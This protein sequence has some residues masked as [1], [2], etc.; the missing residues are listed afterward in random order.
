MNE[1][2]IR[3]ATEKDFQD[4]NNLMLQVH[5][6]HTKA[7]PDIYRENRTIFSKERFS[8]LVDEGSVVLATSGG[9]TVGAAVCLI[10]HASSPNHVGRTVMFLDSIV[11]D[12]EFRN[13]GVGRR[14]VESIEEKGR[15]AGCTATE[16]DVCAFNRQAIEAYRHMGYSDKS[17]VMEKPL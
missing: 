5:K 4:F 6:I 9:K 13:M 16:L 8:E 17:L 11:V 12:E 1:L 2:T 15:A 3:N 7:R 14:L 10:K